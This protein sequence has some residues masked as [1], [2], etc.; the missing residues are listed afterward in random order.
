MPCGGE[1]AASTLYYTHN[2]NTDVDNDGR[3]VGIGRSPSDVSSEYEV[4]GIPFPLNPPSVSQFAEREHGCIP[5]SIQQLLKIK[6]RMLPRD[7]E[8]AITGISG[9]YPY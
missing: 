6:P 8:I 5:S 9:R 7:E 3:D 2:N 1:A 4:D